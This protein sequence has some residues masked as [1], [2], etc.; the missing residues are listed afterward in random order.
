MQK[1]TTN[2]IYDNGYCT[3]EPYF[4]GTKMASVKSLQFIH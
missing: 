4:N 3:E 2:Y 1:F